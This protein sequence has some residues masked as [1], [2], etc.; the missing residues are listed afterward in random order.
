MGGGGGERG[1]G[2][3][4]VLSVQYT[5]QSRYSE[6]CHSLL[7]PVAVISI[8]LSLISSPESSRRPGL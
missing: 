5:S 6:C 8:S 7:Q 1:G 3:S 2:G 4:V